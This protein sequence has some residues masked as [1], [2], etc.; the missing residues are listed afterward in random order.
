MKKILLLLPLLS[1][2]V[3]GGCNKKSK[4]NQGNSEQVE[5]VSLVTFTENAISIPEERTHQLVASIDESLNGYLRFWS[6]EDERIATVND[7]GLVTAVSKGNTIIV[8][9]C[10]KYFARCAV[11]VV[12]YVPNDALSVSFPS[13]TYTLNINDDFVINPTV[14]LGSNVIANGYSLS[15]QSSDTNIATFDPATFT[16]HAIAAGQCDILLTFTYQTQ[17]IEHQIFVNVY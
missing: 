2:L 3:F 1:L 6:S 17:T 16:I 13:E 8:L 5:P 9:Q 4:E 14:K 11:E 10:G 15:A 7:E 12:S